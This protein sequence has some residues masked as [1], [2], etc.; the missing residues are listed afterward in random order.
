MK[1][2]P[3]ITEAE[4]K[5]TKAGYILECS[6]NQRTIT[7][8]STKAV[9]ALELLIASYRKQRTTIIDALQYATENEFS[10]P[11]GCLS[12]GK[13]QA[14]MKQQKTLSAMI[15]ICNNTIDL[16]ANSKA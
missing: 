1:T 11:N 16:I 9:K 8:K 7:L 3:K 15:T 2:N 14:M 4:A 10:E 5:Q 12:L 6:L 13:R